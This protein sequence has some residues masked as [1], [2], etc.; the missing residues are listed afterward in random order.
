MAHING[1]KAS[2]L[3]IGELRCRGWLASPHRLAR[4]RITRQCGK[5]RLDEFELGQPG[6]H[7]RHAGRHVYGVGE[8]KVDVL[9]LFWT[10][11]SLEDRN[12]PDED[13]SGVG[14][15]ERALG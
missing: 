5:C 6:Q 13:A 3:S 4:H 1:I 2:K 10:L 8:K 7:R 11:L 15:S 9:F 14:A 12:S